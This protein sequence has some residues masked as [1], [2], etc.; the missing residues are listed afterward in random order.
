M[1]DLHDK[2]IRLLEGGIV[3]VDTHWVRA[4]SL[5]YDSDSCEACSM[6]SACSAEM[7]ALCSEVECIARKPYILKFAYE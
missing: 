1:S 5:F 3:Q 2:A 7:S 4:V 6:D